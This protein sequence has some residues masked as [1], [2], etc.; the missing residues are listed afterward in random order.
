MS[1][2][3]R[4]WKRENKIKNPVMSTEKLERIEFLSRVIKQYLEYHTVEQLSKVIV[5]LL[6]NDMTYRIATKIYRVL[7]EEERQRKIKLK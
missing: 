5:K 3:E 4:Y 2:W 6:P 1:Y 7:K